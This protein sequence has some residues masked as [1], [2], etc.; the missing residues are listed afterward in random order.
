MS[1]HQCCKAGTPL[2]LSELTG[3]GHWLV[4]LMEQHCG[5]GKPHLPRAVMQMV[6]GRCWNPH[7]SVP[8]C[9]TPV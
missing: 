9:S 2:P 8:P 5:V 6:T 7:E 4:G 1:Q 3:H